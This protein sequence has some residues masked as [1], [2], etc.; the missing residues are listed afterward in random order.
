MLSVLAQPTRRTRDSRET[1]ESPQFTQIIRFVRIS[2]VY[3]KMRQDQK[4][5]GRVSS[6]AARAPGLENRKKSTG[7]NQDQFEIWAVN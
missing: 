7:S 2:K 5:T 6:L 3:K 1:P 4:R